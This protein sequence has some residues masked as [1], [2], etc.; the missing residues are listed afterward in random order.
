MMGNAGKEAR[1]LIDGLMF[2][3]DRIACLFILASPH[4]QSVN[5]YLLHQGNTG[6][7]KEDAHMAIVTLKAMI[8][9]TNAQRVKHR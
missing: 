7:A 3:R 6:D 9:E 4:C 8:W 1:Q 5:R 2:V